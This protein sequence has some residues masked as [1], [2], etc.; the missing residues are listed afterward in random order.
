M[1]RG[2]FNDKVMTS[3]SLQLMWLQKQVCLNCF[4]CAFKKKMTQ[5]GVEGLKFKNK[6]AFSYEAP[7]PEDV[8]G[9]TQVMALMSDP[10]GAASWHHTRVCWCRF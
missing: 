4:A 6:T 1:K 2:K 5:V 10:L 7:S 3:R 9:C 8:E